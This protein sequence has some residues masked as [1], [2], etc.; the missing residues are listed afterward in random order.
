MENDKTQNPALSKT[1]VSGSAFLV[2]KAQKD[3]WDWYLLPETLRF[4][5]LTSQHKY[6]NDNAIK[7][8]FLAKSISEQNAIIIDWFDSVFIHIGI[9]KTSEFYY[10]SSITV[11]NGI[12]FINTEIITHQLKRQ[13]SI[14]LSIEK[15]NYIYNDQADR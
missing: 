7:V 3:F 4:Y 15:A 14:K 8:C 11:Q 12:G 5:K 1:A 9:K 6:S 2:G 13:E 10:Q